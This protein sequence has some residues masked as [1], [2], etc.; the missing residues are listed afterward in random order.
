MMIEGGGRGEKEAAAI[1][2]NRK[3]TSFGFRQT[4]FAILAFL[5]N[6]KEGHIYTNELISLGLKFFVSQIRIIIPIFQS[7]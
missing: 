5:L 4:W 2:Q 1:C 3:S 6:W 7:F